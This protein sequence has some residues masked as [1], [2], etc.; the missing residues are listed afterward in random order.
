MSLRINILRLLALVA[1]GGCEVE[2]TREGELPDVKVEG[3]QLPK[4][5]VTPPDL[6]DLELR[7]DTGTV[8][9]PRIERGRDTAFD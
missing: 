9:I 6:P 7:L 3:G 1:V 8:V 4:Y 5:E 2:Q